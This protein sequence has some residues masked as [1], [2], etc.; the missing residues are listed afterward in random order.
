MKTQFFPENMAFLAQRQLRKLKQIVT[1]HEYMKKFLDLML[2]IKDMFEED[3]LFYFLKGL[4]LWLGLNCR[5]NMSKI[6]PRPNSSRVLNEL[7]HIEHL[8]QEGIV[9]YPCEH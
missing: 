4:K 3:K 1:V 5:G 9:H 2:D 8:A 6:W 7:C